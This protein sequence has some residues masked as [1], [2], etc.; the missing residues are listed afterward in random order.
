MP[1]STCESA[2]SFVF[3]EIQTES[4]LISV[5]EICTEEITGG[6]VSPGGGGCVDE[7]AS[8]VPETALDCP[9]T[10]PAASY[11]ATVYE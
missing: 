11:A 1:Y 8:V 7:V 2:G 4:D 6:V 3:Q 5:G 10:F 9:E